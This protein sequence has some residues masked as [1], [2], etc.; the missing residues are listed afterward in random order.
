MT[1]FNESDNVIIGL[2][3]IFFNIAF[4]RCISEAKASSSAL[5]AVKYK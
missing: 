3:S 2:S 1:L 5:G 4:V